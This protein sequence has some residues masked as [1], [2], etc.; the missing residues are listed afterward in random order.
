V[1]VAIGATATLAVSLAGTA[2][3][4]TPPNGI[5]EVGEFCLYYQTG[6]VGSLSDFN[7]TI[8]NHGDTQPTCYE[9][10][11]PGR[12]G[13]CVKNNA[14]SVWNRRQGFPAFTSTAS[15]A[16]LRAAPTT[17]PAPVGGTCPSPMTTTRGTRSADCDG[18]GSSSDPA[19]TRVLWSRVRSRARDHSRPS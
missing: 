10:K 3:A 14:R 11:T 1:A 12:Q 17:P 7:T 19:V 2:N 5:C 8:P 15:P 4:A 9:F 18:L 6:L 16:A 13:L